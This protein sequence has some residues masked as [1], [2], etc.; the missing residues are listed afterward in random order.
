[1]ASTNVS[2]GTVG[3]WWLTRTVALQ[4]TALAGVG[5]GAAG[6]VGDREERDYHYGVIPEGLLT[7]RLIVG[8]LAMLEVSDRQ[9]H[10]IGTGSCGAS[11]VDVFGRELINHG[12]VG[13]TVRV[14][15]PHALGLHYV[16]STRD[17]PRAGR[18]DLHQ[19]VQT[20]TLSYNFLGQ[21]RFGAVEWRPGATGAR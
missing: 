14:F 2:L 20:L 8:D 13:L 4:G 9:Y 19:S 7:L 16:V 15:G 3:Q 21:T 17:A 10:V 18:K 12:T 6:T 11:T 5:F 1:M